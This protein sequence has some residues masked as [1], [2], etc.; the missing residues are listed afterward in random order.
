MR[1]CAALEGDCKLASVMGDVSLIG[2]CGDLYL[3]AN[4]DVRLSLSSLSGVEYNIQAAGD[5]LCTLPAS[6][7]LKI[8]LSSQ[9]SSIKIQ[10]PDFKKNL[11]QENFSHLLGDGEISISIRAGGEISL[12]AEE[13]V[14]GSEIPFMVDYGEQIARQVENQISQQME[15]VSQRLKQQMDHLNDDLNRVGMSPEEAQRIVDQAMRLSERE[16]NRAQEKMRR[17]QQKLERK[18]EEAQRKTEQKARAAERS[19]W[20]QSRRSWGRTWPTP[21][22]SAQPAADPGGA[23]EEERLMI[24]RMLEEKKITIDEAENLLQALEDKS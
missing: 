3:Q 1:S 5:V 9:A 2:A 7:G 18:L 20:Q 15:E 10:L 12:T 6:A 21:P 14:W 17:A 4:G 11:E 8:D 22:Q 16:T 19:G 13:T 24:L 23:S